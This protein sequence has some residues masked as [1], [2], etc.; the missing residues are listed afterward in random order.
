MVSTSCLEWGTELAKTCLLGQLIDPDVVSSLL[1]LGL[2]GV[3]VVLQGLDLL[4]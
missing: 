4:L 2:E 1:A 3:E